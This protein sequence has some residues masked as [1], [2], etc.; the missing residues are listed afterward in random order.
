MGTIIV[1]SS[2]KTYCI[3]IIIIKENELME[4]FLKL[5]EEKGIDIIN[6][7]LFTKFVN[8]LLVEKNNNDL[9]SL[10]TNDA[11]WLDN[12]L[13]NQPAIKL[14]NKELIGRMLESSNV[15]IPDNIK[16]DSLNIKITKMANQYYSAFISLPPFIEEEK[17]DYIL[18]INLLSNKNNKGIC[19]INHIVVSLC[20]KNTKS[21][22]GLICF[23]YDLPLSIKYISDELASLLSYTNRSKMLFDYNAKLSSS[24]S[25]EDK[26]KLTKMFDQALIDHDRFEIQLPIMNAFSEMQMVK[27][28]A[29]II[30][31]EYE[32]I[33][34][35]SITNNIDNNNHEL[36]WEEITTQLVT[37]FQ[38]FNEPVFWKDKELKYQ[39]FNSSFLQY[40]TKRDY[41]E[42]IGKNDF[43]LFGKKQGTLFCQPDKN[44]IEGKVKF[45]NDEG[46]F[47]LNRKTIFYRTFKVPLYK[48]GIVNGT[49]CFL[50]NITKEKKY[51]NI[52]RNSEQ[53]TDHM[54]ENSNIPYYIKD[55]DRNFIRANKTLC[56]IFKIDESTLIG[57]KVSD[58]FP[59]KQSN[60]IDEFEIRAINEKKEI[61]SDY[62]EQYN[63][64]TRQQIY[65]NITMTPI[66]DENGDFYRL[67]GKINDITKELERDK[68]IIKSYNQN[69]DIL[70]RDKK[71]TYIRIDLDTQD[72]LFFR[73]K[74]DVINTTNLK[75]D[76]EFILSQKKHY[77]FDFEFEKFNNKFSFKNLN[78]AYEKKCKLEFKYSSRDKHNFY[79]FDVTTNYSYNPIT[80]HREAILLVIDVT[81]ITIAKNIIINFSEKEHDFIA[82][83]SMYV[84]LVNVFYQNKKEFDFSGIRENPTIISFFDILFKKIKT[85]QPDIYFIRS[86]INNVIK[87]HKTDYILLETT[88][89][90]I[91]NIII[92]HLDDKKQ[93]VILVSKDLTE[94]NKREIKIQKKL[95]K[96]AEEAKKVNMQNNNFLTRIT[97]DMRA[98][99]ATIMGLSNFGIK[100]T[101]DEKSKDYFMKIASSSKYLSLL[102]ND[103]LELQNIKDGNLILNPTQIYTPSIRNKVETILKQKIIEKNINFKIIAEN[104]GPSYIYN[105][106]GRM[107][108]ILVHILNNAIKYSKIN[109]IV[110]WKYKYIKKPTLHIRHIITD[111]GIGMNKKFLKLMSNKFSIE[112]N[113]FSIPE[114]GTGL[115][116][117]VINNLLSLM[118]GN[119]SCKSELNK[120]T[121]FIIEMPLALSSRGNFTR[122]ENTNTHLNRQILF[123]KSILLCDNNELNIMEIKKILSVYNIKVDIA[124]NGMEGITM[125][126]IK[127]YD[128]ILMNTIMPVMDGLEATTQIRKTFQRIPIIA[129]GENSNKNNIIS[130][131]AVG[132]DAYVSTP[133]DKDVLFDTLATY[134]K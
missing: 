68:Q 69:L 96:I 73:V 123:G 90:K 14:V 72:I 100:E 58:F 119:I 16:L 34:I 51:K 42:I 74:E 79:N 17:K 98:P 40:F 94:I 4:A 101:Q 25:L 108:E 109:G 130:S 83:I 56:K 8:A 88:D 44:I 6:R 126:N 125:A 5:K 91:K 127:S 47:L 1:S 115:G 106:E 22:G 49:L 9:L 30:P 97:H 77:I 12:T 134:L 110:T 78:E 121:T 37:L 102:L 48:K 65:Y 92:T 26:D 33:I 75:Y 107:I 41:I 113:E 82:E 28:N 63:Y 21:K 99:L 55:K 53:I 15:P 103:V 128:A 62:T 86:I 71:F 95:T 60:F 57:R 24:I 7:E 31:L 84:D 105:D 2:Y 52:I 45:S 10:L 112:K 38:Y 124:F 27:I 66:L 129:F 76:K 118:G 20:K 54:F 18:T 122:I 11:T 117:T 111:E 46:I 67:I 132:M 29:Q 89:G 133:I 85:P 131:L 116:L 3:T 87:T 36:I 114:D 39:G 13:S 104:K 80:K 35:A 32:K 23:N 19:L 50:F 64:V 70:S 120:G 59:P 61:K 81:D 93:S 43:D